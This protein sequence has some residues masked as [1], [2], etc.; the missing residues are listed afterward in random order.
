MLRMQLLPRKRRRLNEWKLVMYTI[1]SKGLVQRRPRWEKK[2]IEMAGRQ[3]LPE[4][5]I[6][7]TLP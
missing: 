1:Q 4:D 3:D 6:P 2:E 5:D 7:T